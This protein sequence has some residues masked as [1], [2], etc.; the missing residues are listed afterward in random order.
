M[1]VAPKITLSDENRTIL[2][3]WSRGRSTPARLILRAK[4]VLLAA[5]GKCNDVIAEELREFYGDAA[6]GILRG[7]S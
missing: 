6:R 4:V 3:R 2:Q 1:R 5:E 7:R